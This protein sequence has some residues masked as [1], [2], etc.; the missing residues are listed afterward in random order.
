MATKKDA[1]VIAAIKAGNKA[2]GAAIKAGDANAAAALYTKTA[3]LLPTDSPVL[4]SHAA[5]KRYWQGAIDMGVGGVSLRTV[6]VDVLGTT[7][8]EIGAY[9]IKDAKG[10]KLDVGKYVV[11]WKKERSKWKLHWDIFNSNGAV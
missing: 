10:N 5:I 2:L 6:D 9:T 4:K 8:N 1:E 11:I 3:R 7:A